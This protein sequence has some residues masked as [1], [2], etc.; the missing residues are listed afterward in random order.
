MSVA[1]TLL[2]ARELVATNTAHFPNESAAYRTARNALLV[3]E[4]ELRRHI[5]DVAAKRRVLSPMVERFRTT[6][7]SSP[8]LL[9]FASPACS[10]I[11]TRCWF[12]A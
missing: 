4:I 3:Q 1:Q 12:T 6:S 10:V 5:E 7:R 9:L 2:P 8:R 11:K